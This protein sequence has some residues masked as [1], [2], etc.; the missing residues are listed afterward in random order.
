M[1]RSS[2]KNI[3]PFFFIIGAL[4]FKQENLPVENIL[5]FANEGR[6]PEAVF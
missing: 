6:G 3:I 2:V 1:G 4:A 5:K